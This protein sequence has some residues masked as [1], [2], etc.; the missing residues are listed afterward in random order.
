MIQSGFEYS[1]FA[2]PD[3]KRTWL[4]DENFTSPN[5]KRITVIVEKKSPT[6]KPI[7]VKLVLYINKG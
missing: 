4:V 6:P 5:L 2:Y 1:V 7:K 3:F